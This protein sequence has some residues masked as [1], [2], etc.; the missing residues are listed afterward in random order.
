MSDTKICQVCGISIEVLGDN[1]GDK[2]RVIFSV[3]NPGT[4]SRLYARVCQFN[5]REG[6][7]NR[8]ARYSKQQSGDRYGGNLLIAK[9]EKKLNDWVGKQTDDAIVSADQW[10]ALLTD[11]EQTM[12]EDK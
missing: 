7:I 2:D 1:P 10:Q 5:N 6:C 3:G 12:Q 8:I 4:R 9:E 11:Y